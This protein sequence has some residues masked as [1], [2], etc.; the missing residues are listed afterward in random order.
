MRQIDGFLRKI[1]T[2]V[3]RRTACAVVQIIE[4]SGNLAMVGVS[5]C[6]TMQSRRVIPRQIDVFLCVVLTLI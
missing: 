6:R 3:S 2:P 5:S 4:L 1:G